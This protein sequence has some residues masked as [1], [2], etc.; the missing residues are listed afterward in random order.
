MVLAF[1]W[2]LDDFT[3]IQPKLRAAEHHYNTSFKIIEKTLGLSLENVKK[4]VYLQHKGA[5]IHRFPWSH[6]SL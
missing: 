3:G 2:L 4:R 1:L 5:R 6:L